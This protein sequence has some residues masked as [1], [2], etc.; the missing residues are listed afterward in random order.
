MPGSPNSNVKIIYT[1]IKAAPPF[2]PVVVGKRHI[3]PSPTAEPAV[4]SISPSLDAKLFL[5]TICQ[6]VFVIIQIL[7]YLLAKLRKKV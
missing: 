4:A 7:A 3:L 6:G 5:E 1:N 2:S